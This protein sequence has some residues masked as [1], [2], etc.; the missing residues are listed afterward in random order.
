MTTTTALL[1]TKYHSSAA[2][3][4]NTVAELLDRGD[5]LDGDAALRHS[6]GQFL[7]DRQRYY[8]AIDAGGDF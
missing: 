1:A 2:R 4:A 8:A 7:A 5:P 6:V 3:V